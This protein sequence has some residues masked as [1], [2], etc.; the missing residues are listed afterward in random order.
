MWTAAPNSGAKL[1]QK[2]LSEVCRDFL[3]HAVRAASKH[4]KLDLQ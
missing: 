4:V 1:A 3:T 2:G